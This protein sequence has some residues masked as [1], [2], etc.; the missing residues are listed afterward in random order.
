MPFS[1]ELNYFY[2]YIKHHLKSRHGVHVERGDH[3]ILT[4]P[5][6]E[7]LR[8]Q[9]DRADFVIAD[10]SGR[11]PNVYYELGLA[12]ASGKRVILVS[13]DKPDDVPTDVRHFEF[14]AHDPG[15]HREFLARLDN[16]VGNITAEEL[17]PLY[18]KA[19]E[20][21]GEFSDSITDTVSPAD[22][23]EFR[24][25]IIKSRRKLIDLPTVND[26]VLASHL[27]PK[28]VDDPTDSALMRQLYQWLEN[29]YSLVAGARP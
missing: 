15:S 12:H 18:D 24:A 22:F 21:F 13:S 7:K 27:L 5:L 28:I 9:I 8:E 26:E 16:A 20:W 17:P 6:L 23:E 14:I 3:R 1:P 25:R 19:I 2:L 10:I 11:N 29:K 4:V